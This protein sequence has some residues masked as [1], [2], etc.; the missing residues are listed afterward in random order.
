M[1]HLYCHPSWTNVADET[2]GTSERTNVFPLPQRDALTIGSEEN[3]LTQWEVLGVPS[4]P[5]SDDRA[6]PSADANE[7]VPV[8]DEK[9]WFDQVAALRQE[10]AD[11]QS[12]KQWAMSVVD[13]LKSDC[14]SIKEENRQ[15]RLQLTE[16]SKAIA[17]WTAH[18]STLEDSLRRH[19]SHSDLAMR[20]TGMERRLDNAIV[21][22]DTLTQSLGQ[23]VQD[24]LNKRV[25]QF[26][27][28]SLKSTSSAGK[29][30]IST[31]QVQK[32]LD[33]VSH[34]FLSRLL[35]IFSDRVDEILNKGERLSEWTCEFGEV[36]APFAVPRRSS[37][38]VRCQRC[39]R[40]HW[41]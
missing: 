25:Q 8:F 34:G 9:Y 29:F 36:P 16:A 2:P 13:Q 41:H 7:E 32:S 17:A 4:L 37:R 6:L 12:G 10:N 20:I 24:F 39:Q 15:L 11:L 30:F 26:K 38:V 35:E 3:D 22:V 19:G 31:T 40:R 5:L 18:C 21:D 23:A 14:A 33:I 27:A 28:R 1:V